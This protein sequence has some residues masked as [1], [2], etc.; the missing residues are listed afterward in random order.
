MCGCFR[1]PPIA[2]HRRCPS[3]CPSRL[4]GTTPLKWTFT[5]L[6]FDGT[7]T[8]QQGEVAGI[9]GAGSDAQPHEATLAVAA[10]A[11][12]GG[13]FRLKLTAARD[14]PTPGVADVATTDAPSAQFG[15]GR[16]VAPTLEK[17][18]GGEK[19]VGLVVAVPQT[20]AVGGIT[21]KALQPAQFVLGLR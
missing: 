12:S 18:S 10:A 11:G 8:V 13:L 19:V 14:V 7:A 6:T 4:T 2:A 15:L 20:V 5:L 3:R 9:T 16:P 21:T 1:S 17:V